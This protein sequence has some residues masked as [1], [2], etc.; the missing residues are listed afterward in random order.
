MLGKLLILTTAVV[1]VAGQS[2]DECLKQ[3]SISCVQKTLYRTAKEL[4]AK[5]K[6]ELV[7][8]I[9]L[10]KSDADTRSSR[11]GKE[12]VYDQEMDAANDIVGRQNTLENFISD[13]AGQFLT[14]RSIRVK[15][16]NRTRLIA[17]IRITLFT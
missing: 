1:L 14:G 3:D 5:D 13:K 2:I 12:L 4:F 17:I 15:R 8:G 7:S 11:S 10:V 16:H 9:S 6:L